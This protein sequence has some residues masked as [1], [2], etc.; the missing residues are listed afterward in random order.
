[1]SVIHVGGDEVNAEA[2]RSSANC[3]RRK[4]NAEQL[5]QEFMG[6]V[7]RRAARLGVAVQAWDDA[8]AAGDER[9]RDAKHW[10][11]DK[12]HDIYINAWNNNRLSNAFTYADAGYKVSFTQSR[13][14]YIGARHVQGTTKS[15]LL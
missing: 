12:R 9:P 4:L 8:L 3:T 2:Y 1:M 14:V 7:I 6:S 11:D 5:K 15:S 13:P 10:T